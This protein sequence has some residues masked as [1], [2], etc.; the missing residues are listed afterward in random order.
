MRPTRAHVAAY[1]LGA[2]TVGGVAVVVPGDA[3]VWTASY[4]APVAQLAF[5]SRGEGA[6]CDVGVD[7][8]RAPRAGQD[9]APRAIDTQT[10]RLPDC[11]VLDAIAVDVGL[12]ERARFARIQ[13]EGDRCRETAVGF[14]RTEGTGVTR[15]VTQTALDVVMAC[16]RLDALATIR[17]TL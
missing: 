13:R 17:R 15:R 11:L 12:G 2:A 7:V 14:D 10:H 9:G 16:D 1:L 8:T 3:P 5:I 6:T 4:D